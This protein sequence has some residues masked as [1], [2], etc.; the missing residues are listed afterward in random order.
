VQYSQHRVLLSELSGTPVC[1]PALTHSFT[2]EDLR[3]RHARVKE[4]RLCNSNTSPICS[5]GQISPDAY[6]PKFI[7][8]R[9]RELST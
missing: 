8:R 1:L 2:D 4:S 9:L 3:D 7:Y 5:V 6:R